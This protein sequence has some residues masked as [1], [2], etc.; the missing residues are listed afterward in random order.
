MNDPIAILMNEHQAVKERFRVLLS[1]TGA[2][3]ASVLEEIK[4]MLSLHNATEENVIYPAVHSIAQRPMH[5]RT[6]YHE[7]DDAEVALWELGKL[8][9]GDPDFARKGT[10]LRDALLAHVEREEGSEFKALREALTE[11]QTAQLADDFQA[12]RATL[13]G[14]REPVLAR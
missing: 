8:D 3:R 7:Q 6:L 10:E 2:E 13:T 14:K 4:G 5:A 12:F 11:K 1:S 9:P